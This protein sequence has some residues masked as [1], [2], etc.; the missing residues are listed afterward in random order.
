MII[1]CRIMIKSLEK[2]SELDLKVYCNYTQYP[3]TIEDH[4]VHFDIYRNVDMYFISIDTAFD[5]D[6]DQM[7]RLALVW[8]K[9][10][11]IDMEIDDIEIDYLYIDKEKMLT[12]SSFYH[13][14]IDTLIDP[15]EEFSSSY[16]KPASWIN[17][18]GIFYLSFGLPIER[19]CFN[20]D[21][22]Q[23]N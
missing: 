16:W 8:T 17:N 9:K 10:P 5:C 13:Q 4:G 21:R 18:P 1:P 3:Y 22:S 12:E 20:N 14:I 2:V 19:W 15:P 6:I 23:S 11:Q 7:N